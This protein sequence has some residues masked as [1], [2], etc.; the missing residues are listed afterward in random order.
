[1]NSRTKGKVGE[2]ELGFP[3]LPQVGFPKSQSRC[4]TRDAA[5]LRKGFYE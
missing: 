1:M 2:R 4:A 5:R 3:S